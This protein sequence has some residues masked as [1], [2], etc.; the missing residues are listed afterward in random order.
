M[1]WKSREEV[2]GPNNVQ[3]SAQAADL[4]RFLRA[5]MEIGFQMKNK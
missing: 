2:N 4:G 1:T 3:I 5:R